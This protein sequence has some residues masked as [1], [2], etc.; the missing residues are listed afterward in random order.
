MEFE[1]QR[2]GEA[3]RGVL[4]PAEPEDVMDDLVGTVAMCES[5]QG[6]KPVKIKGMLRTNDGILC[7]VK[8]DYDK[9]MGSTCWVNVSRLSPI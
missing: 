1:V 3:G 8:F 5:L 9:E 6:P 7:F 4:A 2:E